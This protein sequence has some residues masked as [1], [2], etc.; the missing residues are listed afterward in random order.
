MV[1]EKNR[2][3]VVF[4]AILIQLALGAIYAWSAFTKALTEAPYSFTTPETQAVFSAGLFTFALV[5]IFAGIKM[6]T[7]GPKKLAIAG[8]VV[9]GAGYILGAFFGNSF[10][11]QLICIGVIGGAGIG[12]AY[13][14]PIAVGMKWFPDK[15]GLISGLA[16]AGFG[17]GATI[18]VK[19]AGSWFGGLLN[20]VSVFG[21]PNV[22][23][24]FFIYGLAFATMVLVGSIWMVEPPK[25]FRPKGMK[26][27]KGKKAEKAAKS[28]DFTWKEMMKMPSF[29]MTWLIFV[30]SGMAGLM[31]IGTIKLFGI[32]ALQAYGLTVTSAGMAAGTA[33]AWYAIFNGLGRIAWGKISDTTG[34]KKA[35]FLMTLIQGLLMLTFFR[36]GTNPFMLTLYA[37]AIGFN[38]GGNFAL[39]PVATAKLFG[40]KNVG[41]NY[42]FVFTA[43]GIA[44][45]AGPLLGGFVRA[46]TGSFLMAFIPAGVACLVGSGVALMLKE[47]KHSK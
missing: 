17:F 15:K 36:M 25:D 28:E 40:T 18:W 26:E 43:Y 14:V 27:E 7:C 1:N 21:L 41:S 3:L 45:I 8:G 6:K 38:F 35:I 30:F 24:V 9:L 39:F 19:L 23:S 29:W 10:I 4:G 47:G 44:G 12:L 2:W 42:P 13:V 34:P 5:M 33:M 22:Q 32:D 20:T 31:V 37:S 11:G 46:S 16:V